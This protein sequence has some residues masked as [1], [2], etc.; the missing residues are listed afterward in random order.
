MERVTLVVVVELRVLLL[1]L[2]LEPEPH[3]QYWAMIPPMVLLVQRGR[4]V[5]GFQSLH[6]RQRD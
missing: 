2:L 3:Q 5:V 1:L 4:W 6:H